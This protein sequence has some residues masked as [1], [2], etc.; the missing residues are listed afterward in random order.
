MGS[1][2]RK[3]L[4]DGAVGEPGASVPRPVAE[5]HNTASDPALNPVGPAAW[6]LPENINHV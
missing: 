5:G 6:G 1:A 4:E 3:L 2:A